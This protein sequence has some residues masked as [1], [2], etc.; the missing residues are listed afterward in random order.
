VLRGAACS[1][2]V[3]AQ[4]DGEPVVAHDDRGLPD[5]AVVLRFLDLVA[6]VR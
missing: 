4:I 3:A 2:G 6:P 1:A 5:R